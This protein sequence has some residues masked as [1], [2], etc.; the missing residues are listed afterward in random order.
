MI[1]FDIDPGE[2]RLIAREM[3]ATESQ[4]GKAITRAL[5]RTSQTLKKNSLPAL[6]TGLDLRRDYS[7]MRERL[8]D[9]KLRRKGAIQSIGIWFGLNDLPV[10]AFKGSPK[11]TATGAEFKGR[12]FP[13]AF[14]KK[15]NSK[16]R[17]ADN[18]KLTIYKRK[19]RARKPIIEQTVWIKGYADEILEDQVFPETVEIFLRHFRTALRGYVAGYGRPD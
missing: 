18:G 6:K 17:P 1:R 14:V 12:T 8:K 3:N 16:Y 11:Q 15:R 19:S 4:V 7:G 10:S 13:G 5:S 9:L 2:I